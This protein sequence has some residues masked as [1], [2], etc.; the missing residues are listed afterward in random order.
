MTRIGIIGLGSDLRGDDAVGHSVL[1]Y[2]EKKE[3]EDVDLIYGGTGGMRLVHD[4][5]GLDVALIIDAARMD[6]EPGDFRIFS[7]DEAE[8]IES[9]R[10]S[11]QHEWDPFRSLELLD[12][13][14]KKRR[15]ILIMG[16]EPLSLDLGDGL[17]PEIRDRISLYAEEALKALKNGSS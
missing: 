14:D 2:L 13:M 1:S 17:S 8:N 15:K 16:I 4:L 9:F 5:E 10:A 3:I 6:L 11:N 7:P 12:I